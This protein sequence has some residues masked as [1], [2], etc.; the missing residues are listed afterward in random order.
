MWGFTGSIRPFG[1]ALSSCVRTCESGVGIE[2]VGQGAARVGLG[3]ARVGLRGVRFGSRV[4]RVGLGTVRV[5]LGIAR[6]G[7][8]VV[9]LGSVMTQSRMRASSSYCKTSRSFPECVAIVILTHLFCNA[10]FENGE[11]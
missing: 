7:T 3:T 9:G 5:G 10:T 2:G 1:H 8:G 6:F 11:V 4:A